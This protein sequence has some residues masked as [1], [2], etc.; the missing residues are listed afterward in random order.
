MV[1]NK[2]LLLH[3]LAEITSIALGHG[4]SGLLNTASEAAENDIAFAEDNFA[5][6]GCFDTFF[7]A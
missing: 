7:L 3:H 4:V 1:F 5:D 6:D 2:E